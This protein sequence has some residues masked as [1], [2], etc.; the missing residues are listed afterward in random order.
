MD[1]LTFCGGLAHYGTKLPTCM[2]QQPVYG[3]KNYSDL[4]VL[5]GKAWHLRVL[6]KGGDFCYCHR[7]SVQYYLH[8]R[9]SLISIEVDQDG[10]VVRCL[11]GGY[12]LVFKFVCIDGTF[13]QY[14]T[15]CNIQ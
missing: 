4:H 12:V 5:L 14:S 1:L 10:K 11:S 7:E 2:R 13:A 9:K 15:V 3:I 8:Q 6:N